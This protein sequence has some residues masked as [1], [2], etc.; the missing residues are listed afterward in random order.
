MRYIKASIVP[1]FLLLLITAALPASASDD[2]EEW[3]MKRS[4]ELD[5]RWTRAAA[6]EVDATT[7]SSTRRTMT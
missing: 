7:E 5:G 3:A 6:R 4:S 2:F 1:L